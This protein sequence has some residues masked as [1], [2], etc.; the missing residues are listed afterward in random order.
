MK[1]RIKEHWF[2]EVHV[3]REGLKI[4]KNVSIFK[5]TRAQLLAVYKND[6]FGILFDDI[7]GDGTLN[8]IVQACAGEYVCIYGAT[9]REA[10]ISSIRCDVQDKTL[11]E[12][13]LLLAYC[14]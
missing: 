8:K 13:K 9:S 7:D 10:L 1:V 12:S 3:D 11:T 14:L 6:A 5:A 2:A 4:T